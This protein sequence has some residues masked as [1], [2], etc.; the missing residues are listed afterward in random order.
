MNKLGTVFIIVQSAILCILLIIAVIGINNDKATMEGIEYERIKA[1]L[2][3]V[4]YS[5][6]QDIQITKD[7]TK[8]LIHKVDSIKEYLPK[9]EKNLN[10]IK[11]ELKELNDVQIIN[12]NDSTAAAILRRLSR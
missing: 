4:I 11:N 10:Q 12:Y 9:H 1:D 8:L 3:K 7:E 6:K 5:L 2:E